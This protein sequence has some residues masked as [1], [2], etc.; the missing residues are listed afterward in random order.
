MEPS[1]DLRWYSLVPPCFMRVNNSLSDFSHIVERSSMK[2]MYA[3]LYSFLNLIRNNTNRL[4]ICGI[5]IVQDDQ[6][7]RY[8][9][10]G[11][12]FPKS[13]IS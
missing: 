4:F 13:D 12:R 7:S 10:N 6:T 2:A 8:L 5:I 11:D 3:S 1:L 9:C